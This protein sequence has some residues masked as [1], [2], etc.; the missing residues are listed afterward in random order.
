MKLATKKLDFLLIY[1]I[2]SLTSFG[3]IRKVMVEVMDWMQQLPAA[4]TIPESF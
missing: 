4:M 3:V 1:V 2:A